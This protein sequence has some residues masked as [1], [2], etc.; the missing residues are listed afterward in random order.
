MYNK[1]I[2]GVKMQS[3]KTTFTLPDYIVDELA[4]FA[5]ELD[6]KKSHIVA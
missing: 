2:K 1:S 4:E 3:K 5:K 6:E